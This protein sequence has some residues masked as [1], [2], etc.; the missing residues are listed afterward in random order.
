[1]IRTKRQYLEY[2]S[3]RRQSPDWAAGRMNMAFGSVYLVLTMAL[4][5]YMNINTALEHDFTLSYFQRSQLGSALLY[6]NVDAALNIGVGYM[7]A[8]LPFVDWLSKAVSALMIAGA[9]LHSG[10]LYGAGFGILPFGASVAPLGVFIIAA[11]LAIVFFGIL[12]QRLAK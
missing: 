2:N 3:A 4:G 10:A 6:S 11:T 1:M 9:L 5:L 8:R 12:G 7:L